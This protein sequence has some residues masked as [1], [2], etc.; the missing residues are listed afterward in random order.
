MNMLNYTRLIKNGTLI[1]PRESIHARKD[2]GLSMGT[3]PLMP[4]WEGDEC[5][6]R[7]DID[8]S[9]GRH[10]SRWRMGQRRGV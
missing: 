6:G 8:A 5:T 1:E 9:P 2:I 7:N 3:Y 4:H 10:V